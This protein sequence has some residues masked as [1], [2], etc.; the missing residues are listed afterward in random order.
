M[1]GLYDDSRSN[2]L[3]YELRT[4][5]MVANIPFPLVEE[6]LVVLEPELEDG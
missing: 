4:S 2:T 6:L 3:E 1:E 5:L